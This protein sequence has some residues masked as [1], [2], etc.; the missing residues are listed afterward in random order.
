MLKKRITLRYNIDKIIF[1]SKMYK[2]LLI[3]SHIEF[4]NDSMINRFSELTYFNC[5]SFKE[6]KSLMGHAMAYFNQKQH[7]FNYQS[8]LNSFQINT[9]QYLNNHIWTKNIIEFKY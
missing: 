1:D 2:S 3:A 7:K 6:T 5:S 4:P 9:R 8:F